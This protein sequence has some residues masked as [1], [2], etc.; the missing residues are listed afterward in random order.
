MGVDYIANCV[1]IDEADFN[2]NL[3]K[4]Q[5]WELV[6]ETPKVKVLTTR[7]NAT[8]VLVPTIPKVLSKFA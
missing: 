6:R 2:A 4:T 7:A 1:F 5:G 8:L 3:R